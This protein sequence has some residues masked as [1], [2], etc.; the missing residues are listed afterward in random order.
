MKNR[1][2]SIVILAITVVL[3]VAFIFGNSLKSSE[4]SAKDIDA[5]ASA[6]GPILEMILGREIE[7]IGYVVRKLAHFTEFCALGLATTGLVI[8]I[9]SRC[10]WGLY[11]YGVLFCL[12]IAVCY[13]FI[14]SFVDR[15]SSVS[16]VLIDFGGAIFGFFVILLISKMKMSKKLINNK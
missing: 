12:I 11:G 4:E 3:I 15:G 5:I 6:I 14:Q 1:K 13:E 16:D 10:E 8:T 9:G 2:T 7:N